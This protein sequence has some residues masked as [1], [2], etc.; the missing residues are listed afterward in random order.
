M[1]TLVLDGY[2]VIHGVAEL[3]RKMDR[4]LQTAREGLIGLCQAYKARRGDVGRIYVVFDGDETAGD[5][6][7]A[8][9]GGVNVLFTRKREEADDRIIG[10]IREDAGR[11]R[12]VIVSNDNYVFN[13]ARGQG[14]RVMSVSEF[15]IQTR[16]VTPAGLSHSEV[17]DKPALSSRAAQHITSEYRKHLEGHSR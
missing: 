12:F 8:E 17:E 6:P 9:H 16:A 14:A 1:I 10:L 4:S 3:V 2:N 7:R 5:S 11:S 13:N 15:Y